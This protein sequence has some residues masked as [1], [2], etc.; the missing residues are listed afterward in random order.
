MGDKDIKNNIVREILELTE[1]LEFYTSVTIQKACALKI[2]VTKDVVRC[3]REEEQARELRRIFD[4]KDRST[5][6]RIIFEK[7]KF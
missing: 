5:I 7:L 4:T 2:Y 6:S 3:E 1:I